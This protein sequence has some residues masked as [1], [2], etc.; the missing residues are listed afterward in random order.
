MAKL[1]P[2][3]IYEDFKNN[4]LS[5]S[6]AS[7]LLISVIENSNEK[8]YRTQILSIKLL[9]LLNPKDYSIF[10]FLEN[11]LI[12][13][14]NDLIRGNAARILINNFPNDAIDPI[15]WTLRN[16]TSEACVILIIKAL[17]K[18]QY[19]E[20]KRL[21]K[22]K[23][24][25]NLKGDISFP[26]ENSRILNLNSKSIEKISEIKGLENLSGLEK[27]YLNFNY[28]AELNNLHY[29]KNLKSLH[30]QSNKIR[31][32]EGLNS[33]IKLKFLYLNNNKISKIEGFSNL[34]KLKS[35]S[36]YD[37]Q[38]SEIEGLENLLNLEILNLRNNSIRKITNLENLTHLKRL[39]LSNN[40]INEIEGLEN[41]SRLEFL[42]LSNNKITEIKGLECLKNLKFLDL[43]NNRI[44]EVNGI[45]NLKKLQ[46]LYLGF[47]KLK[48]S[49][50]VKLSNNIKV[51]DIKNV[52]GHNTINSLM[53]DYKSIQLSVKSPTIKIV[54]IRDVK[55]IPYSFQSQALLYNDP[56]KHFTNTLW[57]ITWTNNEYEIFSLNKAGRISW[58]HTNKQRK[59]E[60]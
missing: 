8:N 22:I 30:L 5:K 26:K 48:K 45:A 35:L 32:I 4:K 24:Y 37:N 55:Y 49:E 15:T 53:N 60:R 50:F 27:L 44:E 56:L 40:K 41:L 39:D 3:K 38:I 52:K 21:L 17:E 47:N 31:E 19:T 43:R 54:T 51:L 1:I 25:I 34:N 18:V 23:P 29:L 33:L 2:I 11:L 6:K 28:I 12:S 57:M 59:V 14:S 42:D 58:I 36:I 20:L 46:H 16:E 9:G 10:S 13:D 7:E